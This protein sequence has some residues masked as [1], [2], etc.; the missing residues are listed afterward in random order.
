MKTTHTFI[1]HFW[2]KKK[3]IRKDGTTPIYARIR[4]DGKPAD[5]STKKS[6]F[7][8]HWCPVSERVN[9]K[10][11]DASFINDSLDDISS[12]LKASYRSLLQE[13]RFITVQNI[14]LRYLEEDNPLTTI[15]EL[16]KYHKENEIP[17]LKKGTAKN[18]G[19]TEKYLL[20]F[21]SKKYRTSD[22][23]LNQINY[24]FVL[25]FENYLRN[26]TPLMKSQPLGNNGIM[27]H[28][29][30]FKKM[31]TI[32]CKLDCIKQNPFA[33]FNS[34][35]TSYDRQYLTIEELSLVQEL[36]LTDF[37][38]KRVRDCFI[39]ACYTGLSYIDLKKL[40][41]EQIVDGIDGGEWIYTKR[42]KSKTSVKIPLLS[43][44]KEI[45]CKYAN[46]RFGK[47]NNLLLP[48]YSNQ[49]CNSYL[50]K[51]ITKCGINK[52]ISFHAARHTFATTVTLANGVPLETVSKL[53]GHRR[54][55]TTQIYA[56]VM[57]QKI[58]ADMNKLKQKLDKP[59]A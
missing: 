14:K 28:L 56:R 13:G 33:F 43:K 55:S 18:Y 7:E 26:C 12:E 32:A 11:K 19:A 8:R 5:I 20:S 24:S 42:E 36:E 17:K 34:K 49:K 57:E 2:L 9:L 30:R 3:S 15:R 51:I 50:K 45:L 10:H 16:L 25:N 54:L 38:L 31:T 39:F 23:P 40:K 48:V 37:G 47:N 58:S 41:P 22:M 27:K 44:A 6:V 59:V 53:L 46:D 1:I 52:H 4:L 21:L 29:E 35:F